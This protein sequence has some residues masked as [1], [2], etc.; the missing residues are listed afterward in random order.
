MEAMLP[1]PSPGSAFLPPRRC[2][3]R[4]RL[5]RDV[6]RRYHG[7]LLRPV[8]DVE[9]VPRRQLPERRRRALGE[10]DRA[11]YCGLDFPCV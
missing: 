10:T 2:R 5:G 4:P 8:G 11:V 7:G 9:S 3:A 1:P 6:R